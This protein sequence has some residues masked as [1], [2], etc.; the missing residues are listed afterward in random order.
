[1]EAFV[2]AAVVY[3]AISVVSSNMDAVIN[4]IR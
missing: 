4:L 2:I 3:Q 1:M